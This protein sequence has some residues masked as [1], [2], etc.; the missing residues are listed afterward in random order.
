M[1]RLLPHADSRFGGAAAGR[2]SVGYLVAKTL[3]LNRS[4]T[5]Q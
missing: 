2:G 4:L 5:N 3:D 1:G